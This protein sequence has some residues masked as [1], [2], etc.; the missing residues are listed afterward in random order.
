[1]RKNMCEFF[2]CGAAKAG[3]RREEKRCDNFLSSNVAVYSDNLELFRLCQPGLS[4]EGTHCRG[5][6]AVD[7]PGGGRYRGH[8]RLRGRGNAGG[9]LR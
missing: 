8:G 1:M 5:Y 4:E 6:H 7:E 2:V 3:G 9:I